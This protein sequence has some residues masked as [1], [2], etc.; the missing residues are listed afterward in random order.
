MRTRPRVIVGA[1]EVL[2][3]REC[4]RESERGCDMLGVRCDPA[5]FGAGKI[6][7]SP[8]R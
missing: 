1:C 4:D 5:S 8:N 7:G 6:P 2:S 3:E